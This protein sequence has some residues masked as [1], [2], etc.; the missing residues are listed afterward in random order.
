VSTAQG[1]AI[2]MVM[3]LEQKQSSW[4][5]SL[6]AVAEQSHNLRIEY[7]THHCLRTCCILIRLSKFSECH[8]EMSRRGMTAGW[9]VLLPQTKQE[10]QKLTQEELHRPNKSITKF[11][12]RTSQRVSNRF[13]KFQLANENQV[14]FDLPKCQRSTPSERCSRGEL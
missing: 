11:A 5:I 7:K 12:I 2:S 1:M 8:Q 10:L 14:V 13:R 4:M 3:C 9:V 6:E